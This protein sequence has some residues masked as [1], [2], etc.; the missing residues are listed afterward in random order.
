MY[1]LLNN[2]KSLYAPDSETK[3]IQKISQCDHE[4]CVLF[5][6]FLSF[7]PMF[8]LL[9]QVQ[10]QQWHNLVLYKLGVNVE[11]LY[12]I[13]LHNPTIYKTDLLF[14]VKFCPQLCVTTCILTFWQLL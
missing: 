12:D 6:V 1:I 2:K 13:L 8:Q 7:S 11:D 5:K 4:T 3:I 10:R 14:T 9:V